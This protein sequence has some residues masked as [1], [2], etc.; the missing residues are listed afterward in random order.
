MGGGPGLLHGRESRDFLGDIDNQVEKL[1]VY[2]FNS[3]FG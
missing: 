1:N 3:Q 2:I